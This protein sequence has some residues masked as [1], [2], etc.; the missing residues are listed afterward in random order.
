MY[1]S[2]ASTSFADAVVSTS[3]SGP[4]KKKSQSEKRKEKVKVQ[5]ESTKAVNE[6]FAEKLLFLC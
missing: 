4:V 3:S 2:R 5:K 1:E 6:Q